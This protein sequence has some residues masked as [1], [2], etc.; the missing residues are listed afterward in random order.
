MIELKEIT[1]DNFWK[2]VN[3][4]P[5]ESQKDFLPSNAV[6]MAQAYVNLKLRH[7]DTCFAIYYEAEPVGFTKIVYVPKQ[8]EPYQFAED[9]YMIDA[10]MIDC[11]HQ[12]KGYGKEA[13]VQVLNYIESRP[14]GEA[15]SIK[16][17]CYDANLIA[18]QIYEKA[19]F[20]K[21]TQ[22]K[23]EEKKLRFY[24]KQL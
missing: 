11:Q 6:F 7:P 24:S 8:V 18:C 15:T 2:I 5:G 14:F 23:N 3:L 22:F 19:G 4:K 9:S 17:L 21:T 1:W 12:G 20:Q 10:I 16:L 13:L